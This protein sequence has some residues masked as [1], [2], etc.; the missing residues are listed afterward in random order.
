MGDENQAMEGLLFTYYKNE[1][2][3]SL[4]SENYTV[5]TT[6]SYQEFD[7]DDSLFVIAQLKSK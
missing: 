1:E 3:L 6:L 2:L 7:K 5:L 4:I